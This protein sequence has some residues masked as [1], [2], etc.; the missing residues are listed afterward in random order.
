[1]MPLYSLATVVF[2]GKS[3]TRKGG[4]NIIEPAVFG[5]P[6]MIGPYM[7]N[8][9]DIAALFLKNNAVVQVADADELILTLR[10][11]IA[12]PVKRAAVGGRARAVVE[13]NRGATQ[14][15]INTI[16]ERVRL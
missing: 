10:E 14:R 15:M 6:I 7:D 5:K 2:V 4:H 8:F 3:L 13:Q 12:D 11:I 1:M 16:T 9:K